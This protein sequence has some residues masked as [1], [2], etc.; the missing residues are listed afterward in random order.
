MR[1][2]SVYLIAGAAASIVVA[3]IAITLV[4]ANARSTLKRGGALVRP[5]RWLDSADSGYWDG[6]WMDYSEPPEVF[7]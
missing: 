5:T 4:N 3:G 1:A 7:E 2:R 6:E